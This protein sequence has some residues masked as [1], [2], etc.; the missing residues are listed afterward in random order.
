MNQVFPGSESEDWVSP[1]RRPSES[2]RLL[3]PTGTNFS[4]ISGIAFP[5]LC[6]VNVP[7]LDS[8]EM[9]WPGKRMEI[10]KGGDRVQ[11]ILRRELRKSKA[12]N[13]SGGGGRRGSG[14]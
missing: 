3:A 2:P 14:T 5:S 4:I 9:Q 10:T 12:K 6:Q 11:T 8:L 1:R 13:G 7:F